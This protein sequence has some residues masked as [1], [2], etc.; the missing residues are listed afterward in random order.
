MPTPRQQGADGRDA[1]TGIPRWNWARLLKRVFALDLVP[2]PL[3]R[4]GSLWMIAAIIHEAV[5]RRIVRHLQLAAVLP[6]IAPARA[7]QETFDWGAYAPAVARGLG[8]D[9]RATAV[10][11][12][13]ERRR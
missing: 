12:L 4:R 5:I 1:R 8:G 11:F 3:C 13:R 2:C 10:C 6:P 7:C 9:G